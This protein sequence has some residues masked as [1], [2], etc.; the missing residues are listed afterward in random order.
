MFNDFSFSAQYPYY[1]G[2]FYA[3]RTD[4]LDWY[5]ALHQAST[6]TY[7]GAYG[8]LVVVTSLAEQE[9]V[10]GL[11]PESWI[12]ANDTKN[13]GNFAWASGLETG[14]LLSSLDFNPW[15]AGQPDG[16]MLE[17]CVFMK[18]PTLKWHDSNCAVALPWV[19]E[20]QCGTGYLSTSSGC[21]GFLNFAFDVSHANSDKFQPFVQRD[22]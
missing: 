15:D 19:I 18:S 13:Q 4:I 1:N 14:S 20:F 16:N 17:S 9:F 3:Y 7:L 5:S 2:S 21:Q 12:A 6:S 8:H 10:S 22:A 11:G